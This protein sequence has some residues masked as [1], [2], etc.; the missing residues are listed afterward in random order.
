M[1]V[2]NKTLRSLILVIALNFVQSIP[3]VIC[4]SLGY[5]SMGKLD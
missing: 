3:R 1:H 2:A 5:I 4:N